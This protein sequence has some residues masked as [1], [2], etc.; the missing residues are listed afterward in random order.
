MHWLTIIICKDGTIYE[1]IIA[2]AY[3]YYDS[4]HADC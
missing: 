1:Q 4:Y 2:S 3:H